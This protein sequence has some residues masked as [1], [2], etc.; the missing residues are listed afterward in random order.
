MLV[1]PSHVAPGLHCIHRLRCQQQISNSASSNI[2][3]QP[4]GPSV[5]NLAHCSILGPSPKSVHVFLIPVAFAAMLPNTVLVSARWL[6]ASSIPYWETGLRGASTAG[7]VGASALCSMAGYSAKL[8]Q[9]GSRCKGGE[10]PRHRLHVYCCAA[11]EGHGHACRVVAMHH[12]LGSWLLSPCLSL[13][14]MMT[15]AR[16][17][18][19]ATHLPQHAWQ[20]T[21]VHS[22][23]VN[24][25]HRLYEMPCP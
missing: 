2:S 23:I 19:C 18:A 14:K 17:G 21:S 12:A 16:S 8:R 13:C 11:G 20:P 6:A 9:A 22:I 25:M 1:F 3:A 4:V 10:G 15:Q 24:I 7:G 5:C